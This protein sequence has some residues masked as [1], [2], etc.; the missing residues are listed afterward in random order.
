MLGV[1]A[2]LCGRSSELFSVTF[3]LFSVVLSRFL[4]WFR[5]VRM[6]HMLCY[7]LGSVAIVRFEY[8]IPPAPA[9]A[10][11]PK[12]THARDAYAYA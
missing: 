5:F 11:A 7:V 2:M 6:Y 8:A 1:Y 10:P 4:S 3:F 12:P 9:P